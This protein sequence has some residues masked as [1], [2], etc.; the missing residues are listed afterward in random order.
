MPAL[1]VPL[2]EVTRGAFVE[3]VHLGHAVA[4][5]GD[6]RLALALGDPDTVVVLRSSAKPFQALPCLLDGAADRFG[7]TDR[8]VALA[9]GSHEGQPA[10]RETARAMLGKAGLAP[11]DLR[12]GIKPPLSEDEQAALHRAGDA[13]S[14]LH[15]E[16]SGE[17][18]A[19]AALAVH[20]GAPV[21][22]YT[23][24]DHP[25]QRR[26]RDEVGRFAGAAP[27]SLPEATDGCTIPTF[28]VPLRDTARMYA[29]LVAPPDDWDDDRK[30][31]CDRIV[32]AMTA[33]PEMVDGTPAD[34]LLDSALMTA[35]GG[36]LVSKMGA[37]GLLTVGVLPSE[38]WPAGLGLA[39][40]MA[41]GDN[42]QRARG[43]VAVALL[44]RLGVLTA[45]DLDR[46][47]AHRTRPV[48]DNAGET[49]GEVRAAPFDDADADDV[50]TGDATPA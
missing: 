22:T 2:A 23:A 19:M 1:P 13:P 41:D 32:R 30:G 8:E 27:G 3:S 38:A 20:L 9:C 24:P 49:V 44:R 18:A 15:N 34:D 11:S 39:V 21:G 16:C 43:P 12:C 50:A 17:H 14:T 48:T 25:V 4:V 36:R 46:L 37:E 26:V 7:F 5:T 35:A 40:T 33:H 45:A 6:G 28:G 10:H 31:A 29:R 47:E 42:E